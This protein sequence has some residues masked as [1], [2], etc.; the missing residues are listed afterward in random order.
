MGM[1]LGNPIWCC[2]IFYGS[3]QWDFTCLFPSLILRY[4]FR[5]PHDCF[6]LLFRFKIPWLK[7]LRTE[8]KHQ[9]FL[10]FSFSRFHF[11][12]CIQIFRSIFFFSP[13]W[14]KQK[15]IKLFFSI[16]LDQWRNGN[17][18]VF[19]IY[20]LNKIHSFRSSVS[21]LVRLYGSPNSTAY[22][23]VVHW[24]FDFLDTIIFR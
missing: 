14:A 4:S 21:S 2:V 19:F 13:Q 15:P 3:S 9:K 12:S 18:L 23:R 8:Q 22:I 6:F 5:L 17:F 16:Q 11:T 24:R 1:F 20:W 7:S 10:F